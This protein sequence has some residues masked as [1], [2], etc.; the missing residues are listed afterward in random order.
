[1]FKGGSEGALGAEELWGGRGIV[2]LGLV[3]NNQGLRNRV[4]IALDNALHL[5][6]ARSAAQ[7]TAVERAKLVRSNPWW[8]GGHHRW[9][10]ERPW[11]SQRASSMKGQNGV[12]QPQAK[13][14]WFDRE[15]GQR[16]GLLTESRDACSF[17]RALRSAME[18]LSPERRSAMV[19]DGEMRCGRGV[20]A[21][22]ERVESKG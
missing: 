7:R 9:I 14:V 11:T 12:R 8:A 1:M 4:E 2:L 21:R 15:L 19:A 6:P 16:V 3:E 20:G 22:L 10:S 13:S 17:L 5:P 18:A